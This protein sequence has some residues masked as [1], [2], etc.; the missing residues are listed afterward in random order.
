M[1]R[2]CN[3]NAEVIFR[4]LHLC[5]SAVIPDDLPD[6]FQPDFITLNAV[7]CRAAAVFLANQQAIVF[8]ADTQIYIFLCVGVFFDIG[9]QVVKDSPEFLY[10][11]FAGKRGTVR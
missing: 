5:I 8:S 2:K 9:G 7:G 4:Q 10:V 11:K 1:N 6:I 3:S